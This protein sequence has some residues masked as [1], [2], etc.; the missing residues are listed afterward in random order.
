MR[1]DIV[2][3]GRGLDAF[4]SDLIAYTSQTTDGYRA[5]QGAANAA[6]MLQA[7]FT[8]VRDLGNAGL[9]ADT[10]LRRAVEKGLVPGPT[11]VNAGRIIAPFGGQFRSHAAS[12]AILA[13]AEYR[14]RGHPRRDP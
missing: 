2:P 1:V 8:T 14:S 10:D 5:L 11:I 12:G 3:R 9:Y 4:L 7:G 6:S 13:V